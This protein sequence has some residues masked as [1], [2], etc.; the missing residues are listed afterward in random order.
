MTAFTP[1]PLTPF[2]LLMR[3][4]GIRLPSVW[5]AAFEEA[6]ETLTASN[7]GGVDLL[8]VGRAAWDC[9]PPEARNEALD[10]LVYG[11]W[12]SYQDQKARNAWAGE[13]A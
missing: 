2:D 1:D 6:E 4:N 13:S 12:E 11:W 8:D 5:Q 10:A 9:L 7:P 3:A